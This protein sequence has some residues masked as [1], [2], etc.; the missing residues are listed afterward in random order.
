MV[1]DDRKYTEDHEW[2]EMDASGEIGTVGIT[3]FAAGELGDIVF[4][5][6]PEVGGVFGQGDNVGSIESV[7]AV[8]DLL[9]PVSGEIVE[10]NE[11]VMPRDDDAPA[12]DGEV[13][14]P[15]LV[16]ADP[17]ERGWL[18]RVRLSN[19]D[20]LDGLLDARAYNDVIGG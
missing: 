13:Y 20:E 10:V 9:L 5:E 8:G 4:V 14:G 19:P 1:P 6:L 7:K 16:G 11:D 12:E 15:E 17:M 18:V 3:T 2:I